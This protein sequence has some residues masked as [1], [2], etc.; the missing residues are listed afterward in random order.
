MHFE[1]SNFF[2]AIFFSTLRIL[3]CNPLFR[4]GFDYPVVKCPKKSSL[5]QQFIQI[6]VKY[7]FVPT[8]NGFC[9]MVRNKK[10]D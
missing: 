10:W 8:Q 4:G 7:W 5:N 3:K 2:K 6:K 9:Y 1:K